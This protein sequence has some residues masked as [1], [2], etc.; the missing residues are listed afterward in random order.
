MRLILR[1][2]IAVV[3]FLV[4][5]AVAATT[6]CG[7]VHADPK[8][9]AVSTI[10]NGARIMLAYEDRLTLVDST[11]GKPV[12][13]TDSS[14]KVRLDDKGN[15][16]IW[17]AKATDN[18]QTRFYSNPILLDKDTFLGGSYDK[19]MVKVDIPTATMTGAGSVGG[20]VV[21]SPVVEDGILYVGLG[22]KDFA[23]YKLDDMSKLWTVATPFG[24][25]A[26]PLIV[27]NVL[28]FTSMDHFLY[29][30]DKTSGSV[31]WKTDLQ[32]AITGTP[33]YNNG[34]LYVGSFARKI[35]DVSA[36]DGKI[37]SEFTTNDWVW[38]GPVL[39]DGI[40]YAA[41]Q[42]GTVYAL[43]V[44]GLTKVWSTQAATKAIPPSPLITD[45]YVIVGSR[46]HNV[47]WLD[48]TNGKLLDTKATAGEI[49]SEL[50]LINPSDT[51]KVPEPLVVVSTNANQELL[52]AFTVE[53]GQRQW[54]YGR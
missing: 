31:L 32:G 19:R 27:D 35:F 40:L 14:G 12:E 15:P 29:A 26:A 46:D 11:D 28:Y 13:L 30:V 2:R 23:A 21:A 53:R 18:Q 49:L 7:P 33:A 43:S 44:D 1:H 25:W 4:L 48:R 37:V 8:W 42:S 17:E 51:V 5:L 36:A 45:K 9:A 39:A 20:E 6:A 54:A 3:A 52:V 22:E 34:H 50:V 16:R 10:E 47:Y 38:S 41:D 24:V